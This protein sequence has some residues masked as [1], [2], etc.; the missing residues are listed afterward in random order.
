MFGLVPFHAQW[1]QYQGIGTT[2]VTR[3]HHVLPAA[4]NMTVQE[5]VLT[6]HKPSYARTCQCHGAQKCV[7]LIGVS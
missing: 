2:L 7:I 3:T 1:A 5:L 4:E 6:S